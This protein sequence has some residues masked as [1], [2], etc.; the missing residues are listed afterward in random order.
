MENVVPN[1][2]GVLITLFVIAILVFILAG[3]ITNFIR[4]SEDKND[5]KNRYPFNC[6]NADEFFKQEEKFAQQKK[7]HR[8]HLA[9]IDQRKRQLDREKWI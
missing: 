2:L 3:V 7:K 6:K 9:A 8:E 5:P 4:E 1:L